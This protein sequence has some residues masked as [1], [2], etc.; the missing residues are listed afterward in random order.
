ME[1]TELIGTRTIGTDPT[2]RTIAESRVQ[3]TDAIPTA[4][5]ET[6]CAV[7]AEGFNNRTYK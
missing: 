5:I 4:L 6:K 7:L 1:T 2:T 3:I